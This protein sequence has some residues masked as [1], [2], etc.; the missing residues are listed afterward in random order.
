MSGSH[1]P[2]EWDNLVFGGQ[3]KDRF[4]PVPLRGNLTRDTWGGDNVRLR[5]VLNGIDDQKWSYRGG[6]V[7]PETA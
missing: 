7:A 3:F 4:E 6:S 1:R 5:D 2:A